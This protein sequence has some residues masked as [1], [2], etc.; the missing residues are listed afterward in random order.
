MVWGALGSAPL[1]V[2]AMSAVGR[3]RAEQQQRRVAAEPYAVHPGFFESC[4]GRGEEFIGTVLSVGPLGLS[5][6]G[7]AAPRNA[8]RVQAIVP[9][10]HM[11]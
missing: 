2:G 10:A 6:D 7:W 1:P 8:G 9:T 11:Q 5:E 4:E 3:Y